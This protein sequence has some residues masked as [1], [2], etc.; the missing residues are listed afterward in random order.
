[1]LAGQYEQ[2][3]DPVNAA[4]IPA[5]HS[6]HDDPVNI[7]PFWKVPDRHDEQTPVASRN[8]PYEQPHWEE[9]ASENVPDEQSV[10]SIAPDVDEYVLTG[11]TTHEP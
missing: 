10:H 3:K 1:M 11:H 8:A 5:S 9:P 2:L 7:F 4:N 6:R